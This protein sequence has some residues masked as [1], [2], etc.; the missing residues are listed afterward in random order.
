MSLTIINNENVFHMSGPLNTQT[1]DAFK[2]HASFFLQNEEEL[3]INID[4]VNEIDQYG[5]K[6]LNE[7]YLEARNSHKEFF[8]TGNGCREVMEDFK[9]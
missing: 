3:T 1:A 8:I 9:F 4:Q 6:K 2:N 7:L 5:L